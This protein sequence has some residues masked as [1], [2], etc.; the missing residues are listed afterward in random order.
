MS[1]SN[2]T[3]TDYLAREKQLKLVEERVVACEKSLALLCDDFAAFTRKTARLRDKGDALAKNLYDSASNEHK[4]GKRGILEAA[5][6]LSFIQDYRQ[7]EVQRLENK[8]VKPLK[9]YGNHCKKAKEDLKQSLIAHKREKTQHKKVEELSGKER[10]VGS[11]SKAQN[12]LQRTSVDAASHAKV[13]EETT[14]KFEQ[15]RIQDMKNILKDFVHIEMI[16]HAKALELYTTM[17]RAID[18]ID[19]EADMEEFRQTL[20]P[21]GSISRL[22]GSAVLNGEETSIRSES[23][24]VN[25]NSNTHSASKRQT[26]NQKDDEEDEED[27]EEDEEE[28]GDEDDEED[29]EEDED[30]E[31]EEDDESEYV[32]RRPNSHK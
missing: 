8:V 29:D 5:Q 9:A 6:Y 2:T 7:A 23:S 24:A 4:T 13:L 28:D 21:V 22:E 26:Q 31:D 12:D 3:G 1:R 19:E 27:E 16:F 10:D 18:T 15:T 32:T 11:V 17:Y 30:D 25:G 14:E 20:R